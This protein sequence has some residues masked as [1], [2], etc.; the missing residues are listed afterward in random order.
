MNTKVDKQKLDAG[1]LAIRKAQAETKV[2]NDN[3]SY[4]L[5]RYNAACKALAEAKAVDEVKDLRNKAEAIRAYAKQ[6][7][8]KQVE[9]DAMEIRI[10]A[11]RRLGQLIIAQKETIGLN[12]GTRGA[13]RPKK[14]GSFEEPPKKDD[15]PTLAD[16]GVDKKLSSRAQNLAALSSDQFETEVIEWRERVQKHDERVTTKLARV[17]G[18]VRQRKERARREPPPY[19]PNADEQKI[20]DSIEARQR[21]TNAIIARDD[22]DFD[23]LVLKLDYFE[24]LRWIEL[25]GPVATLH[26]KLTRIT[27]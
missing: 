22:M 13:G 3:S 11:E 21:D 15:R 24:R 23:R 5:V 19:E 26:L 7:K 6:A 25:F 2:K 8:N 17:G 9:T 10:R 20:L 12:V 4:Q 14:G 16:V 18:R 1:A 27:R